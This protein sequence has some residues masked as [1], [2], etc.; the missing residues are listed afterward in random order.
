MYE[1]SDVFA[2]C[3][4]SYFARGHTWTCEEHRCLTSASL[5]AVRGSVAISTQLCL[6]HRS[7]RR[8]E[9]Q[10]LRSRGGFFGVC[11]F[12]ILRREISGSA[13]ENIQAL[14]CLCANPVPGRCPGG[15][16]AH[17][18][19]LSFDTWH[20][21][22]SDNFYWIFFFFKRTKHSERKKRRKTC[23]PNLAEGLTAKG[24]RG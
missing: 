4:I 1:S 3:G 8:T 20:F 14:F 12:F 23:D 16:G 6:S 9:T 11:F 18:R 19:P 13:T 7:R 22:N 10:Q 5:L 2:V 17:L 15:R 21:L 24:Q